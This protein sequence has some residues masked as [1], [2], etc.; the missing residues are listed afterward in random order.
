LMIQE[1]EAEF[2]AR[3]QAVRT[4][5]KRKTALITQLLH[6]QTHMYLVDYKKIMSLSCYL[7]KSSTNSHCPR[8]PRPSGN[9]ILI[10][11]Y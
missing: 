4:T 3:I 6:R 5:Q 11:R 8:C 7:M 1:K 9:P 10:S 2:R